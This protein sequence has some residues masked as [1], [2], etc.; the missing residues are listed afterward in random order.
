MLTVG[1]TE[2]VGISIG[3][4]GGLVAAKCYLKRRR[5]VELRTSIIE[6]GLSERQ[7]P[8]VTKTIAC[9]LPA[10]PARPLLCAPAGDAVSVPASTDLLRPRTPPRLTK[11]QTEP[12]V[13]A[14]PNGAQSAFVSQMARE[15]S[16]PG[17]DVVPAGRPHAQAQST[18]PPP[19][20]AVIPASAKTAAATIPYGLINEH[21][22]LLMQDFN[23]S[24]VEGVSL[25][26]VTIGC[27]HD[28]RVSVTLMMACAGLMLGDEDTLIKLSFEAPLR[29]EP[30]EQAVYFATISRQLAMTFVNKK[31][32]VE[33][34]MPPMAG[35]LLS[36]LVQG[37]RTKFSG[38]R[39]YALSQFPTKDTPIER[40]PLSVMAAWRVE[41]LSAVNAG[42]RVEMS[43][44][45]VGDTAL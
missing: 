7:E 19:A 27:G 42:V 17:R 30:T 39:V 32:G 20:T 41:R 26:D 38:Q 13:L 40:H 45:A 37:L 15:T 25:E 4:L 3:L 11:P 2:I 5:D 28:G 29:Y 1:E 14:A 36:P 35:A 10:P 33:S 18:S 21:A 6:Y 24:G 23:A 9:E 12:S 22:R 34:A 44:R 8:T 31:T 16:G 43:R